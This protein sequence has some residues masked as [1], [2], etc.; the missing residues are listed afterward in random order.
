MPQI[1]IPK[2]F[3]PVS[4]EPLLIEQDEINISQEK[5]AEKR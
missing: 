2:K 5:A 3:V 4:E 1:L